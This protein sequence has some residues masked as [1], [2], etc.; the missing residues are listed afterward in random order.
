MLPLDSDRAWSLVWDWFLEKGSLWRWFSEPAN[1]ALGDFHTVLMTKRY[2]PLRAKG[3]RY[4]V[5]IAAAA[6]FDLL[7][8]GS[9]LATAGFNPTHATAAKAVKRLQVFQQAIAAHGHRRFPVMIINDGAVL[10]RDLSP[11]AQSVSFDF[12]ARAI[13]AFEEVNKLECEAGYPGARM[14]VAVGARMR[15]SGVVKSDTSHRD[16][17]ILR[18]EEGE[19]SKRQAVHEAFRAEP[20]A[21]FVPMLQANF[22]FTKA[23][24][25]DDGGTEAG[26][27][28]PKCYIDLA[29]FEDALP[30][31]I[32]F[33]RIQA[34]SHAGMNAQFGELAVLDRVSAGQQ[35]YDGIRDALAVAEHLQIRY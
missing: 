31:W 17:I 34:W 25:A 19:I 28:G 23:Y 9:M 10:F 16:N 11:R 8:Y 27:G 22:A 12:L 18:L 4:P 7:G 24:L 13:D 26:L 29:L 2:S 1:K 15:V 35:Q 3:R 21:G 20:V 33:S 14:V 6:W 5:E 32:S 30:T